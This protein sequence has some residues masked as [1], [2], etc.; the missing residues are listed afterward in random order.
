MWGATTREECVAT[1]RDAVLVHGINH[2]DVAPMYG[3]DREAER[4][5]GLAFKGELPPG[6]KVTTKC[7]LGNRPVDEVY[8]FL[9]ASLATSLGVMRLDKVDLF[10]LHSHIVPDSLEVEAAERHT[11]WSLYREGW[12]PAVARLREEGLIGGWGVTGIGMP[13]V[14]IAALETAPRPDAC[15]CIANC[16]DSAGSMSW[17]NHPDVAPH[18]EPQ[19]GFREVIAACG[20]NSV[21][22]LGIRAVQAGAITDGIDRSGAMVSKQDSK[23]FARAAPVRALAAELGVSTAYLAHQYACAMAVDSVILGVKNRAELEDCVAAANAEPL[24]EE[25]MARLDAALAAT[26]TVSASANL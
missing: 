24:G 16:L 10:I 4:V 19:A 5:V 26:A 14:V 2:L 12:I 23:D 17:W 15:Q 8:D 22:A 3:K 25:V 20:A 6:C 1:V 13:N 7:A 18:V 9:L 11:P 21:A